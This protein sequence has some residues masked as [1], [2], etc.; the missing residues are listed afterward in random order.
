[1]CAI[2][3]SPLTKSKDRLKAFMR[4]V[5]KWRHLKL[6]KRAGRGH[7]PGGVNATKPGELVLQCPACLRPGFNM[8]DNLDSVSDD[9]RYAHGN[10]GFILR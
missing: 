9:M 3:S 8:P 5:H 1:M 10:T 4:M 2:A 6:L 7:E